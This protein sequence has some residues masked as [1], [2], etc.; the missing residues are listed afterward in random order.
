LIAE[1]AWS[2]HHDGDRLVLRGLP[3]ETIAHLK[4]L[5]R[6]E[7]A[8]AF[9]VYPS[10]VLTNGERPGTLQATAGDYEIDNDELCF[11]PRH[12]FLAGTTYAMFLGHQA[13]LFINRP[14]V[15]GPSSTNV[16]AVYPS[17]T[18][19]PRN[20]L[21]F[22]I[23]FSAPMTYGLA[24]RHV[25][26]ERAETGEP[27]PGAFSPMEPELWDSDR[28]RLTVLLDPARIK[29]GLAPHREIGYPLVPDRSVTLAIGS[30][31]LDA[32]GRPLVAG[33]RQ[34]YDVG[35]DVRRH[36]NP[37]DWVLRPPDAGDRRPL[38]VSLD[39]PHDRALLEGCLMV[40]DP[41][42]KIVSGTA[43][44]ELGE[45]V[46]SFIPA[47]AWKPG[48]HKLLVDPVLEDL[49]GNSVVRIFDRDLG[50]PAHA[51]RAMTTISIP[52]GIS[53]AHF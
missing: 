40:G 5:P 18:V 14:P 33:H 6:A 32:A 22:Y 35:P 36:V 50:E 51:P 17:S 28:R 53:P 16:L 15:R 10:E 46:W 52:F 3:P 2:T 7:V 44:V 19:L 48:R 25:H 39:R 38:Q 31:M 8:R 30:G 26:L 20:A 45:Q 47:A 24:A 4:S 1:L 29:R 11:T 27:I 12:P 13:A 23:H 49:A 42:G 34:R 21:R 37:S 43:S 9:S 41:S